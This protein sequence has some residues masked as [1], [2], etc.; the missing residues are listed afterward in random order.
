IEIPKRVSLSAQAAAAIRKAIDE[1]AWTEFIPSERRLCEMFQVSRPTIR[2]ALHLLAKQGLLEI[3]QGKRIRLV[4][5]PQELGR[6]QNRLVG[7]IT[8]EPVEQLSLTSYRSISEMRSHLAEHG[9][10]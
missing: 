8:P 5:R 6:K 3:H 7:L 9:F 1:G 4:G 2:T 10:S